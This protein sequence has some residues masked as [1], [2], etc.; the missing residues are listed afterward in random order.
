MIPAALLFTVF[1]VRLAVADGYLLETRR[2]L[3]AND[4]RTATLAFQGS[5][6]WSYPGA[7]S[8]LWFSR[9]LADS[10]R[11][12]DLLVPRAR[13]LQEAEAA[14]QRATRTAEDLHNAHYNLAMFRALREDLPGVEHSLRSAINRAPNWFKP[15]WTLAQTLQLAGRLQQ[16]EQEAELAVELSGGKYPEVVETL[17]N[18]RRQRSQK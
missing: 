8:D 9:T 17:N 11:K 6:R 10:S 4:V 15:H 3:E 18:I 2:A 14:A 13:M 5:S 7:S 12:I 1:A 16:A